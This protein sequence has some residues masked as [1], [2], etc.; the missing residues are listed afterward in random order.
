M[1]IASR[2]TSGWHWSPGTGRGWEGGRVSSRGR[3]ESRRKRQRQRR[4]IRGRAGGRSTREAE[5]P[6][7]AGGREPGRRRSPA[8]RRRGRAADSAPPRARLRA[9]LR[10]AAALPPSPRGRGGA[11]SPRVCPGARGSFLPPRRSWKR[12]RCPRPFAR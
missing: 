3:P 8:G 6:R 7:R 5:L 10:P 9:P 2:T 4:R 1:I 11:E 12:S